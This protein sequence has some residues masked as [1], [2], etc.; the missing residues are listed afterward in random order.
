M[1]RKI[2][3]TLIIDLDNTIFDWFAIAAKLHVGGCLN[4]ARPMSPASATSTAR[5]WQATASFQVG[6]FSWA[7]CVLRNGFGDPPWR[8]RLKWW[9]P[10]MSPINVAV[11]PVPFELRIFVVDALRPGAVEDVEVG[12]WTGSQPDDW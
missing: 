7:P 6:T 3:D 1:N 4:C 2:V 5:S 11:G 10:S 8:P 12:H 9:R